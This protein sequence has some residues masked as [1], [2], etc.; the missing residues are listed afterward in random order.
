M[1]NTYLNLGGNELTGHLPCSTWSFILSDHNY[2]ISIRY[3]LEMLKHIHATD[4]DLQTCSRT[5]LRANLL[6][7]CLICANLNFKRS[8]ARDFLLRANMKFARLISSH[9]LP[10]ASSRSR[11]SLCQKRPKLIPYAQNLVPSFLQ[12]ILTDSSLELSSEN[13]LNTHLCTITQ[14][15]KYP[16]SCKH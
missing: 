7:A 6:S 16:L 14:Y 4:L 2:N 8:S 3:L 10:L 5:A 9:G 13:G 1:L 12:L 15:P 11:L